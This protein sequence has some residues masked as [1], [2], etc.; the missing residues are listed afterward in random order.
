MSFRPPVQEAYFRVAFRPVP[1]SKRHVRFLVQLRFLISLRS[2]DFCSSRDRPKNTARSRKAIFASLFA[3]FRCQTSRL[4][5]L[6]TTKVFAPA[7]VH[8]PTSVSC[9]LQLQRLTKKHVTAV[10]PHGLAGPGKLFSPHFSPGS[11]VKTSRLNRLR[12]S[13][14]FAPASVLDPTSVTCFLQF[15]KSTKKHVA[16]VNPHGLAGPGKLLSPHISPDAD[17][18]TSRLNPLRT[19]KVFGPASI[20]H[21]ASVT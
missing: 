16:P 14:V 2:P 12:T 7:S 4:N 3:R 1:V 13:K 20:L 6:R 18:K 15:Q 19:N 9:F 21:P 8:D 5:P 17:V 10:N 11:D